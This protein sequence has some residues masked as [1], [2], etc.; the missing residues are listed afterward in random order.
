MSHG[1]YIHT[2][3]RLK[4][5]EQTLPKWP[6]VTPD[7][8]ELTLVV[9][10]NEVKKHLRFLKEHD[11]KDRVGVLG[12][13]D[14]N[15]GMGNSRNEA[16]HDAQRKG[17]ES[18]ITTDDDLFPMDDPTILLETA[19]YTDDLLGVGCYFSMYGLL[20]KLKRNTGLYKVGVGLGFR[21]F[22]MNTGM[23]DLVGGFP[24][25]FKGYDDHEI[26]R[27]GISQLNV[28]WY[29]DTDMACNSVAK[30][31]DPGGMTSLPGYA[32]VVDRKHTAH[33]LTHKNWPGF[34]S[35]PEKCDPDSGRCTY[36]MQWKKFLQANNVSLEG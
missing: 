20:L 12:L 10:P 14:T 22:A 15:L 34:V 35:N 1:V 29:I 17:H 11:L 8:V 16:F 28:P 36:T 7:D 4:F 26:A 6:A 19:A 21:C 9:E 32:R 5:L 33:V 2:R 23:L 27:M 3:N 30:I 31:G 13:S 24:V 18:F 25:E